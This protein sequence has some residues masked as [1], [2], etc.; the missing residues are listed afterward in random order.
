MSVKL[1]SNNLVHWSDNVN[2]NTSGGRFKAQEVPYALRIYS[3]QSSKLKFPLPDMAGNEVWFQWRLHKTNGGDSRDDGYFARIYDGENREIVRLNNT[4]GNIQALLFGSSQATGPTTL[5]QSGIRDYK[6]R[7]KT[8]ATLECDF[9]VNGFQLGGT[10][11]V[12]NNGKTNPKLF[13]FNMFDLYYGEHN[14]STFIMS[15]VELN[16]EGG[17]MLRPSTIGTDSSLGSNPAVVSDD[18]LNTGFI[19]EVPGV[20]SS[21]NMESPSSGGKAIY[22][23]LPYAYVQAGGTARTLRMYLLIGGVKY[24]GNLIA[25]TLGASNYISHEWLVDPSDGLPWTDAK[26]AAAQVGIE[27]VS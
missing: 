19:T 24:D 12:A 25:L 27:V 13:D 14:I 3:D 1:F 17:Q 16:M 22:S 10:L 11:T 8:G 21:F 15:E 7:I 20:K 9:F 2:K 26:I 5:M 6:L 18:L 4:N 23:Y